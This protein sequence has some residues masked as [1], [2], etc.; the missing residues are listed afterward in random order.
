MK[1]G[2]AHATG[3]AGHTS[4]R[5]QGSFPRLEPGRQHLD[6]ARQFGEHHLRYPVPA[7]D[8]VVVDATCLPCHNPLRD[9][10]GAA[11][12]SEQRRRSMRVSCASV[13]LGWAAAFA[14]DLHAVAGSRPADSW[15]SASW[16]LREGKGATALDE[17]SRGN[18][19]KIH[20][21][22]WIQSDQGTALRFTF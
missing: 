13:L 8:S 6:L 14:L 20:R 2:S 9:L 19:G 1:R 3:R 17:S 10:S 16:T 12:P 15:V 22:R 11:W 4:Y 21:P 5:W 7:G 18:H